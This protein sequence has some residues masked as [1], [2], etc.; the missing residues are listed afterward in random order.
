[1]ETETKV[2]LYRG[3]PRNPLPTDVLPK[4][5]KPAEPAAPTPAPS[6]AETPKSD[7]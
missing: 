4:A 2:T 6:D 5:E 7:R 3:E 1:V